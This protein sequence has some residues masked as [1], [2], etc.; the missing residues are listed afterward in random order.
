MKSL[1]LEKQ[2]FPLKQNFNIAHGTRKEAEVIYLK[3]SEGDIYG[4]GESVPYSRYQESCQS[5]MKQI[6]DIRDKIESGINRQDLQKIIPAGAAR[7]AID[8]ALWDLE[9][10]KSGQ[11]IWQ[12]ANLPEA[13]KISTAFT[14]VI[15]DPKIMGKNADNLKDKYPLLK[16]KLA[17]DGADGQRILAVR[18]NAPNN[19]III[20]AN[21]SWNQNNYQD[22]IEICKKTKIEMIE[23]PF[24][25]N[26]DEFL[27]EIKKEITI[28]AD[29]SCHI[30]SDLENLYGKY[31][32]INIKLDKTGGLT[33]ALKLS[34][35][36][37]NMG[38]KIMVGCMVGSSLSIKP[39]FYLAQ[40]ADLVDLDGPLLI[41]N[42]RNLLKFLDDQIYI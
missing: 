29:E 42:D 14:I 16:L 27:R 1:F 26:N 28:C 25:T 7:N 21:E 5:V 39:A 30:S 8:S 12:I 18:E 41:K 20:D 33:E 22:A 38:F 11:D 40:I 10:K 9:S 4:E 3:I 31:D 2:I 36:A 37:K 24:P 6:T 19:R 32:M 23:Q 35:K 17:G 13:K 34:K 15:D